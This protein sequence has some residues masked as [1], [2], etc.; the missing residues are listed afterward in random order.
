LAAEDET[1]EELPG[2]KKTGGGRTKA[3]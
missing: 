1:E 2:R 3:N